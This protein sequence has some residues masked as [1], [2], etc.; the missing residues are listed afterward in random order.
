M[1]ANREYKDSVFRMLFK[2]PENA[3]ELYQ[4]LTGERVRTEDITSIPWAA[5]SPVSSSMTW[6]SG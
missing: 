4:G 3:R 5:F 1:G 2:E 6:L